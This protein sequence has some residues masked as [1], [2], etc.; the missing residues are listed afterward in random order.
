MQ[1]NL[2]KKERDAP[3]KRKDIEKSSLAVFAKSFCKTFL[4]WI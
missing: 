1:R 2:L 4:K 3:G